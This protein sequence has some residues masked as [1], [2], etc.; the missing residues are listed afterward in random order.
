M[1]H[2]K[3]KAFILLTIVFYLVACF[4]NLTFNPLEWG[5]FTRIVY[6]TGFIWSLYALI[7]D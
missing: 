2:V 3:T 1:K 6:I 4:I 7:K 5:T